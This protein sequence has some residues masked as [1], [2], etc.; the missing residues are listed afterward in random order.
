MLA[1]KA[2]KRKKS[3]MF[4]R[5]PL[6]HH[7]QKE[8]LA[9]IAD[10]RLPAGTRINE[11][12]LSADL[13]L[14]RTPLREAMLGLEAVG[15]LKSDMGRGFIVPPISNDEFR[16]SQAMLAKIEPYALTM[17]HPLPTAQIMELNNLL[18]RGRIRV[19][20]PGSEQGGALA[21]LI[22]RWCPLLINGCSN[23]ILVTDILRL[24]ALSRRYWQEAVILGFEPAAMITS[25]N[26]MYELLRTNHPD[27]AAVHWENHILQFSEEAARHL[28]SASLEA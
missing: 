13:G 18:G 22:Y 14:S 20:Q 10:H 21:D 9:R 17:A 4:E 2:I 12:H 15:F 7:V 24:E 28:P 3:E 1:N 27:E 5:K 11:S 26:Q 25:Y 8:I 23:K 16:Q 19:A 6:R